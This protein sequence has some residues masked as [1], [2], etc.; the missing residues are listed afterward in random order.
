MHS[1]NTFS[2]ALLI[3]SFF[4]RV[5]AGLD[6][7]SLVRVYAEDFGEAGGKSKFFISLVGCCR[8]EKHLVVGIVDGVFDIFIAM[9]K[10]KWHDDDVDL[11]L[12]HGAFDCLCS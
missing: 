5:T 10:G 6:R 2:M 7:A 11:P 12:F 1:N 3:F 9:R 4:A 8:K